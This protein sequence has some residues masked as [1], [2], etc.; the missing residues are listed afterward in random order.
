MNLLDLLIL[1]MAASAAYGGY[2]LGLLARAS[3]WIGLGVGLYLGARFLP[4]IV[5]RFEGPD[6]TSRLMIAA[7]VLV[8][9]AFL[10]Q[11]VGLV[12]GSHIHRAL[13][14][15]GFKSADK[16]AGAVIGAFGVA[17]AVWMIAPSMARV[18]G[19]PA[20]LARG[21]VI[22]RMINDAFP[23]AP[24]RLQ[25]LGNILGDTSFPQVFKDLQRSPDT[26]PPPADVGIDPQV[27]AAVTASTVKVEGEACRRIQE[28]SGFAAA[29]D[30]IV[31]NAHVVAGE[32]D[33]STYVIRPDGRRLRATVIAFDP[34]RDLAVL[35]VPGLSQQPLAIGTGKV[36]Q[37]GAVFGHPGGQDTI[38]VAPAAIRQRVDAVG[39]DLYDRSDTRRDVWI[40]AA[41]LRPGDSGGALVDT[42]GTVIGV[43]F[44][45]APDRPSTAY[46]L[47]TKELNAALDAARASPDR[48]DTGACLAG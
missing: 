17:V 33:R 46:A 22:A 27:I 40:L 14:V 8:V 36:G 47:T 35:H 43:A 32:S 37:H 41:D 4:A 28:G 11:A 18:Q 5:V 19:T 23:D 30:T 10:G 1:A 2:R 44:A 9:A 38:R 45:I 39:R 7:V 16:G 31:T 13:P 24:D 26:G 20:E 3:S 25:S 21:S 42:A 48:A 12:I 15:G 29:P 6:P 34:N